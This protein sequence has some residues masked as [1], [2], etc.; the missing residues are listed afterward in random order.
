MDHQASTPID[1]RVVAAMNPYFAESFGNP[2]STDHIVGWRAAQAVETAATSVSQLIGANAEEIVFTSGATEANN[3]ALLGLGRRAAGGKRRRILVSAI[4]HKCV[5]AVC[6][7]LREQLGYT[8]EVLPVDIV[9][10]VDIEAIEDRMA[11][12]VLAVSVMA[13]NNEIGTIQSIK[14]ISAIA[15]RWNAI[16]HCDAAQAPCAVDLW[17]FSN[18]VDLLSLSAHKMYGPQGVGALFIRRELHDRIEPLIYGGGQQ[19]DLRS[20]TVPVALC[21]GMGA[22]AAFFHSDSASKERDSLRRRRDRFIDGLMAMPWSISINGPT[23][24]RRHPCNANV[25]FAGFDGH[26]ILNVLQPRL[27]ASMGSACASGI[28]EPSH[29][30]T[31]IGLSSDAANSSVRFSI[32]RQTTDADIEEAVGLIGESLAKLSKVGLHSSR[33]VG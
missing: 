13:V 33:A 5:L 30:L 16:L 28:P 19:R 21:V 14:E 31:A 1:S 3:Q 32:G 10:H 12:D 22:A 8:I 26:T 17:E 15:K 20:G 18:L 6:R 7:V 9:G 2:H 27:A 11:D 29:V 24:T 25:R 23:D 4:E